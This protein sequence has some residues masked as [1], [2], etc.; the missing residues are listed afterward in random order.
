[1]ARPGRPACSQCAAICPLTASRSPA[2]TSSNASAIRRWRRRWCVGLKEAQASSRS[3]SW[4][5]SYASAVPTPC[6]RH[7][8]HEQR[9]AFC[10]E[11]E[12]V[13]HGCIELLAHNM[14]GQVGRFSRRERSEC[15][16][17]HEPI[18]LQRTQERDERMPRKGLLCAHGPNE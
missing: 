5:K 18:S 10:L 8:Y 6:S 7:F 15:D 11:I 16:F 14:L 9:I 2:Y 4:L 1:M 12:R 3:L 17:C 13:A